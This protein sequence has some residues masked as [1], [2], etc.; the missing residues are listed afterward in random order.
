MTSF[1]SIPFSAPLLDW[2]CLPEASQLDCELQIVTPI[3]FPFWK[4]CPFWKDPVVTS[5]PIRVS[6]CSSS[7]INAHSLV[8]IIGR[9]SA[10]CRCFASPMMTD[11]WC[12]PET[13]HICDCFAIFSMLH[14]NRPFSISIV[15]TMFK[16]F[17]NTVLWLWFRNLKRE[18]LFKRSKLPKPTSFFLGTAGAEFNYR[19]AK[20]LKVRV[21]VLVTENLG[22]CS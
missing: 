9:V 11:I 22:S 5:S 18:D 14:C 1:Q 16:Y 6:E 7:W 3:K 4:H 12:S 15:P 2:S 13:N 8:W 21:I 10:I 19:C 20:F 17:S